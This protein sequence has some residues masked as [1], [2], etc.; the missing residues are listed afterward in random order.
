MIIGHLNKLWG[1]QVDRGSLDRAYRRFERKLD[2]FFD[3]DI[4]FY[5]FAASLKQKLDSLHCHR[6]EK[7]R[8][9]WNK[10]HYVAKH[11]A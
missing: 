10:S 8:H 1:Y 4:L 7:L 3:W 2:N 6:Y 11:I 5:S 9:P